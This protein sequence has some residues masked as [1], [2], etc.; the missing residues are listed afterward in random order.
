M[1]KV[2]PDTLTRTQVD[3]LASEAGSAGDDEVYAACEMWLDSP[4]T[5]AREFSARTICRVLNN[6][7]AMAD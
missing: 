7:R 3:A 6:A 2:T 5:D 1:T 4:S